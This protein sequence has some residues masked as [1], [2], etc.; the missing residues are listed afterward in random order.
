MAAENIWASRCDGQGDT[1]LVADGKEKYFRK[2][3]RFLRHRYSD[4]LAKTPAT[5]VCADV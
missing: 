5:P 2:L 1:A 3:N 4:W